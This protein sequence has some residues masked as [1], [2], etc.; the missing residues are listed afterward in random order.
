MIDVSPARPRFRTAL[1]PAAAIVAT[2]LLGACAS[3]PERAIVNGRAMGPQMP[4]QWR[5][6]RDMSQLRSQYYEASPLKVRH[7]PYA[8]FGVWD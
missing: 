7:R 1:L 6:V 5:N 8:P 4:L 3:I 2:L